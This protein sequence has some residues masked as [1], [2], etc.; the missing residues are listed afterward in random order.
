MSVATLA[1]PLLLQ[2]APV[3]AP[4]PPRGPI[5][6]V[7]DRVLDGRGHVIP[8]TRIVVENGKISRL[9][10]GA[11]GATYDL[12]GFTVLPGWIDVHV[13][14]GSYFGPDGRIYFSIGQA[15]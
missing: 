1:L 10:P 15:F 2:V 7:A 3:P 9:D 12:R 5:V 11:I 13:H 8:N 4:A 6:I 14:I